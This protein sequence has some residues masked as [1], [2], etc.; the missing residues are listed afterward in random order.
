M[1]PCTFFISLNPHKSDAKRLILSHL[2][3]KKSGA[4][5]SETISL[6]SQRKYVAEPESNPQALQW[7]VPCLFYPPESPHHTGATLQ[8]AM[9]PQEYAKETST[10]RLMSTSIKI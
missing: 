7:K 10:M 6:R 1:S 2:T 4:Q 3:D 9:F 8:T 5:S